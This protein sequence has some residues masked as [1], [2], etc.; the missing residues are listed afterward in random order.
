[1]NIDFGPV[2]LE[3]TTD[4]WV[5]LPGCLC[6]SS[7]CFNANLESDRCWKIEF[8]PDPESSEQRSDTEV[9]CCPSHC[10]QQ[11]QE[12]QSQAHL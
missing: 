5:P 3:L 7:I 4:G 2:L 9:E 10:L 6:R 12:R 1:M 8:S 11:C